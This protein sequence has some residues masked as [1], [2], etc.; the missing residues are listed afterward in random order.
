VPGA[1]N[2]HDDLVVTE[3]TPEAQRARN[4]RGQGDRLRVEI[5]QAASRVLAELGGEQAVTLR[6]VARAAG[7]APASMY[8]H[9]VDKAELIRGL[10]DY[11]FEELRAAMAE[12]DAVR[13]AT[14]VMGRLRAQLHAYSRFVLDNPGHYR[15]MLHNRRRTGTADDPRSMTAILAMVTDAFGR[16]ERAGHRLRVAVDRA[17]VMVFVGTHGRVALYHSDPHDHD[18][19][20]VLAFVDELIDLVFDE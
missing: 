12:A 8:Q 19:E 10:V 14:D 6:G 16:C 3:E 4:P 5:L 7:I 18:T 15:L 9:F 1:R 13:P 2:G 11:D 17:A 20:R